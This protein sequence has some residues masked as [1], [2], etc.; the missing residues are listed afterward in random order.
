MEIEVALVGFGL[1]GRVFHAPIIQA[2]PGLRLAAILQRTGSFDSNEYPGVLLVHSLNELL[3]IESLRLVVIAT[4]NASHFALAQRCLEAGRDVVVEKPLATSLEEAEGLTATAK[5]LGRALTVFHERRW[6][7]DFQ[8]VKQIVG[9]GELGRV[10]RFEA[11]WDRFR[12]E[13]NSSGW[14]EQPEPGSGV[15]FDLGSHLIDQALL[16]FG[17]PETVTADIRVER[18]GALTDDAFDLLLHYPRGLTASLH[19]SMLVAAPRP[20]YVLHGTYG[21]FVKHGID[22]QE[23][24][25]RA[26]ARPTGDAWGL[27]P[28]ENWGKL[29]LS[30]GQVVTSRTVPTGRGDYRC[31][32]ENL[33]DAFLGTAPLAISPSQALD[34]MRVLELGRKSSAHHVTLPWAEL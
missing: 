19:S 20:R 21:A 22:P 29:T 2:V 28:T 7:G 13:V 17:P 10:V 30:D 6:D 33:R 18:D 3:A 24:L 11:H 23:A 34:V 15:L 31:F 5:S 1:S 14:R 12:P 32:Y 26:G 4:P 27:E 25:L 9:S 8:T 16:L